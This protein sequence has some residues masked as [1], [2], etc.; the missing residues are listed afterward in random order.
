VSTEWPVLG[1]RDAAIVIQFVPEGGRIGCIIFAQNEMPPNA[2]LYAALA[3]I[4]Q[5]IS[6]DPTDDKA[7]L[8]YE[9]VTKI[10]RAHVEKS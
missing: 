2:Y 9:T 5:C 8:A 4:G 6:R 1:P 3:L 7:L 10:L